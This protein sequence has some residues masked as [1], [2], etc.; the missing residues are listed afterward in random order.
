MP[1]MFE[2]PLTVSK[3]ETKTAVGAKLN[4]KVKIKLKVA[5]K[6]EFIPVKSIYE[7]LSGTITPN[8][9]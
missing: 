4:S 6:L 7:F 1:C 9:I 2:S 8:V 3:F 5:M